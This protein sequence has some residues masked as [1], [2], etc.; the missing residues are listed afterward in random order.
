V[1]TYFV[2]VGGISDSNSEIF[3]FLSEIFRFLSEVFRTLTL[4][5]VLVYVGDI[6]VVS[7][8]SKA[9]TALL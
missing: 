5:Y 3:H 1:K 9:T 4:L 6:I 8:S 2:S 7:S